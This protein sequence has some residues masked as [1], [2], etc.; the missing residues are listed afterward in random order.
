MILFVAD[1]PIIKM[2]PHNVTVN[3]TND[4]LIFCDYEANPASLNKVTW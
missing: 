2:R 3:E 1:P 4:F